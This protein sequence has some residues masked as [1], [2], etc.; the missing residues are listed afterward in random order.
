MDLKRE[1]SEFE[2]GQDQELL[3]YCD[4]GDF[5]KNLSIDRRKETGSLAIVAAQH[6]F[7]SPLPPDWT[8][9]IEE[10]S[11]R[12]YFW[13][14]VTGESGWLHPQEKLFKS[15]IAEVRK[16]P[17]TDGPDAIQSK[18]DQFI[19][20]AYRDALADI[21]NWTAYAA[22]EDETASVGSQYYYNSATEQTSWTDP[23]KAMQF[24]LWQRHSLL[25]KIIDDHAKR[26]AKLRTDNGDPAPPP[27]PAAPRGALEDRTS[28]PLST[29]P[30]DTRRQVQTQTIGVQ[31]DEHALQIA[32][33]LSRAPQP[34]PKLQ[35][36]TRKDVHPPVVATG[37][38]MP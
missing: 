11:G 31:T 24:D 34:L 26:F 32:E 20:D 35:L 9:Q 33:G 10:N 38:S 19:K 18:G 16:W 36:G 22:G 28:P 6:M 21:G 17:D 30:A 13:N 8:E 23:R 27:P 12:V 25:S 14:A 4:F 7:S 3:Q 29:F 2:L 15:I 37:R 1:D 5:L